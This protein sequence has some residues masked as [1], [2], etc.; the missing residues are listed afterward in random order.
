MKDD[1]LSS[2]QGMV[3]NFGDGAAIEARRITGLY[4]TKD[5]EAW[6]LWTA[7]ANAIQAVPARHMVTEANADKPDQIPQP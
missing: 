7:I 3:R 4:K 2:A 5:T 1:I 6:K